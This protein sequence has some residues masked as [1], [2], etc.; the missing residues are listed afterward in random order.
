MKLFSLAHCLDS[1]R[2]SHFVILSSIDRSSRMKVGR[3][4]RDRSAPGRS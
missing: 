3:V 4:M 1:Q 2:E